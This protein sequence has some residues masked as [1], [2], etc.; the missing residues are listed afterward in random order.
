MERVT[1]SDSKYN[2]LEQMSVTELL[3]C[4]NN[5]DKTVAAIV[6]KVIPQLEKLVAVTAEKMKAGV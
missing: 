2:D 6:E 5:E 1:E 3:R 4:I